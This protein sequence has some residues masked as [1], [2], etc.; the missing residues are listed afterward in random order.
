MNR[1]PDIHIYR[2]GLDKNERSRCSG[3]LHIV[4]CPIRWVEGPAASGQTGLGRSDVNFARLR[5]F[6]AIFSHRWD[7]LALLCLAEG[8]HRFNRL[9]ATMG[10][11]A[12][13]RLPDP[14]L[15]RSLRRLVDGNLVTK[16]DETGER[17]QTY[18]LTPTGARRAA[19]LALY[20][21]L[22]EDGHS[23][24]ESGTG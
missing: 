14:I 1:V 8:P 2:K 5:E 24:V 23:G 9:A 10:A 6:E 4:I 17:Y 18:A 13:E 7:A 22:V 12:D 21:R 15:S 3:V 11:V 16:S 19:Q 20:L